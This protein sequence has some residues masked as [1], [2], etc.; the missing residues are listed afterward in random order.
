MA[1][2]LRDGSQAGGDVPMTR[3][4]DPQL[5]APPGFTEC[6]RLRGTAVEVSRRFGSKTRATLNAGTRSR[7]W[8]M[9]RPSEAAWFGRPGW[10]AMSFELPRNEA[11]AE[12][13]VLETSGAPSQ[14]RY[15][16][17]APSVGQI[18]RGMR[19]RLIALRIGSLRGRF[20]GAVGRIVIWLGATSSL[21]GP[22]HSSRSLQPSHSPPVHSCS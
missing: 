12:C 13:T 16:R 6:A 7:F 18:S 2:R 17:R 8:A 22:G 15:G 5:P 21:S 19:R 3:V 9:Q 10:A 1:P 20:P 11:A 14:R 4:T